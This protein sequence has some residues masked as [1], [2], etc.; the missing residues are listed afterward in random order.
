MRDGDAVLQLLGGA[1]RRLRVE[2]AGVGHEEVLPRP[3]VPV[4]LQERIAPQTVELGHRRIHGAAAAEVGIRDHL[5]R[6]STRFAASD[7]SGRGLAR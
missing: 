1:E 4:L 3:P 2:A 5:T 7:A 6:L